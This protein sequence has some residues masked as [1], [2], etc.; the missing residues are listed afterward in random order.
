MVL[1][2]TPD[3]ELH[4]SRFINE[5]LRLSNPLLV[6]DRHDHFETFWKDASNFVKSLSNR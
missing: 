6:D 3:W 5:A 2:S 4:R 1:G